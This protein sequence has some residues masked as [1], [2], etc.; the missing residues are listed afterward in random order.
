M[1]RVIISNSRL[2]K[3]KIIT[4]SMISMITIW[5]GVTQTLLLYA[6]EQ[7][8]NLSVYLKQIMFKTIQLLTKSEFFR[9]LNV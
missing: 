4:E 5:N 7:T 9:S 3:F 2:L 6:A 1:T 8:M